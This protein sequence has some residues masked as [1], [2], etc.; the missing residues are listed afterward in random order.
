MNLAAG[1]QDE[2]YIRH[3]EETQDDPEDEPPLDECL[4]RRQHAD[5]VWRDYTGK[6][7]HPVYQCHQ[8]AGVIGTKIQTVDFHPGIEGACEKKKESQRG[9]ARKL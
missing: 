7:T 5:N 6:G 9:F 2:D 4:F 1:V 3:D 8:S